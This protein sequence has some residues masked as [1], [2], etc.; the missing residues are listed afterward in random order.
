M[1]DVGFAF[2]NDNYKR[3]FSFYWKNAVICGG[4][5]AVA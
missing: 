4:F 5:V 2:R 1:V 3:D